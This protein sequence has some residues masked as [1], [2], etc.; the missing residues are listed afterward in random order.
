MT[1]ATGVVGMILVAGQGLYWMIAVIALVD[2][3][4]VFTIIRSARINARHQ[5]A[6]KLASQNQEIQNPAIHNTGVRNQ[7]NR[8]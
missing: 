2:A 8:P 6:R 7:E 1:I 3:L 5:E 4:G